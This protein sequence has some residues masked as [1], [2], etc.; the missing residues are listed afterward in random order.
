MSLVF[1]SID[2]MCT[3]SIDQHCTWVASTDYYR[4]EMQNGM[5]LK[6]SSIYT[7]IGQIISY[8]ACGSQAR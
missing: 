2:C 5:L 1:F 3:A 7:Q 8:A 6:V 4:N